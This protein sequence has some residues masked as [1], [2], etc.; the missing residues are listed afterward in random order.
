MD[1]PLHHF[2]GPS[3]LCI[4]YLY[5][6]SFFLLFRLSLSFFFFFFPNWLQYFIL[7]D[8]NLTRFRYKNQFFHL[9]PFLSFLLSFSSFFL[10]LPSLFFFLSFSSWF[11]LVNF[12]RCSILTLFRS[13]GKSSRRRKSKR[14]RE[15]EQA[16]VEDGKLNGSA[17]GSISHIFFHIFFFI[18]LM[19]KVFE[20]KEKKENEK[21]R[22]WELHWKKVEFKRE[23]SLT[24][25]PSVWKRF[26]SFSRIFPPWN[27]DNQSIT[28]LIN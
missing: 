26:L 2:F 8:T 22:K 6:C 24:L 17:S 5:S 14:W 20:E 25:E 1:F 16:K 23:M 21:E 28:Q 10:F 7:S 19:M 18:F 3:S 12:L 15:K 9:S 27:N 11:L 13:N 4:T